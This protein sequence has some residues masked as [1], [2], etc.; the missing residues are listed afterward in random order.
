MARRLD[1]GR[2]VRDGYLRGESVLRGRVVGYQE[3]CI[4]YEQ[5]A[6][7]GF[8]LWGQR[9]ERALDL[10]ANARAAETL[11]VGLLADART[12]VPSDQRAFR[13]A[14]PRA[15]L[16]P[17]D[18]VPPPYAGGPTAALRADRP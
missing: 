10:L 16:V 12:P 15:R 6:A 11:G 7:N 18:P 13:A 17:A 14:R 3:G 2:L 1:Y 9:V 5:Y 8:A 4:G